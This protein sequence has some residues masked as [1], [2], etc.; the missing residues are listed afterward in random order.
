MTDTKALTF[1]L[2]ALLNGRERSEEITYEEAEKAKADGLV[3]AFG[4]SD[5]NLELHGAIR[6]EIGCFNGGEFK[7]GPE[8][9]LEPK[10]EHDD[11]TLAEARSYVELERKSLNTIKAEFGPKDID[12]SWRISIDC[13]HATFNVMEDGELFCIG[14]VFAIA[15]LKRP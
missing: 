7:V 15:D 9:I 1:S 14:I 3:V 4:Y 11:L 12:C 2:A 10:E 5:D 8:A 6:D 13:P